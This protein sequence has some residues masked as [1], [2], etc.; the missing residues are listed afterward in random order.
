ML[1]NRA[2]FAY[3]V[4]CNHG[5]AVDGQANLYIDICESTI[6]PTSCENLK[7]FVVQTTYLH[8]INVHV[9]YRKTEKVR[10]YPRKRKQNMT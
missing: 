4:D 1:L 7:A 3:R 10:K 2:I 9:L 6:M 8:G 5:V